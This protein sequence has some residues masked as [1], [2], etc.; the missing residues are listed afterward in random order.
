V[1]N[2]PSDTL[3]K[4][5]GQTQIAYALIPEISR[6]PMDKQDIVRDAFARSLATIWRAAIGFASAGLLLSLLIG[7]YEMHGKIDKK[8]QVEKKGDVD[9]D[10][11]E[12]GSNIAES[13]QDVGVENVP[14]LG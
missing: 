13:D 14:R 10:E 12:K 4:F 9:S 7:H 6:L 11:V 8:W 1:K 2:L 3:A 5:S